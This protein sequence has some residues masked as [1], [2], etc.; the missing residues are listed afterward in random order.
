VLY[1]RNADVVN[2]FDADWL[3]DRALL[4]DPGD[5]HTHAHTGGDCK[6]PSWKAVGREPWVCQEC[7]ATDPQRDGPPDN[8]TDRT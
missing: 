4:A 6:H 5:G 3:A 1:I 8:T 7:G 2:I